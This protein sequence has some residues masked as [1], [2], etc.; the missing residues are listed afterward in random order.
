MGA[1]GACFDFDAT[2]AGGPLDGSADSTS[3]ADGATTGDASDHDGG[4]GDAGDGSVVTDA[5]GDTSTGPFCAS[6]PHPTSPGA[7]FFCDDFDEDPLPGSWAS[8]VHMSGT[9][10]ETNAI[11]VSA[12][13]S[14]DESIPAIAL[15]GTLDVA[16]RT[17]FSLPPIPSTMTLAFSID[18]VQIDTTANSAI[19]LS[20]IDFLDANGGRYSLVLSIQT[21]SGAATM[22]FSEQSGLS[23]GGMPYIAHVLAPALAPNTFTTL[24]IEIDW[25][26]LTTAEAKIT[27]GG[28]QALDTALTMTVQATSLQ[29]GIG[30]SYVHEPSPGWELRYDNVVFSAM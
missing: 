9:L 10:T 8:Y 18:P 24:D 4:A 20:A 14:L 16:L 1:A 28:L 11:S 22:N 25:T 2:I 29:I 17:P 13:N 21:E 5:S 19:V 6:Y 27:V 26:T 7:L 3:T 12:P 30:T 15:G 23:D